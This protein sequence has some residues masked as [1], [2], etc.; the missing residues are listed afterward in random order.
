M[1]EIENREVRRMVSGYM[2]LPDCLPNSSIK[3]PR[4]GSFIFGTENNRQLC[5]QT[6]CHGE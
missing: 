6:H 2:V 5:S 4:N 3:D 1:K